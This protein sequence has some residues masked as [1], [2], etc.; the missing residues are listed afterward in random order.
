MLTLEVANQIQALELAGHLGA[1]RC[2]LKELPEGAWRVLVLPNGDSD[3]MT[4]RVLDIA[5]GWVEERCAACLVELDG[6]SYT[7]RPQA[8]PV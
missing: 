6:R 2:E 7:L 8:A 5:A 3:R 4:A 1:F